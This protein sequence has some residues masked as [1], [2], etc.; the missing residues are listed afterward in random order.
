MTCAIWW[1]F[2]EANVLPTLVAAGLQQGNIVLWSQ[3]H[4][5]LD[6]DR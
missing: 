4:P 5:S 2:D 1:G 6:V 3:R